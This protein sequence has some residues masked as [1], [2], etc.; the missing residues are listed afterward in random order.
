M[1]AREMLRLGLFVSSPSAAA[2][3]KPA[4]DRKPNTAAVATASNDVPLGSANRSAS[5]DSWP[6]GAAPPRKAGKERDADRGGRPPRA[7]RRPGGQRDRPRQRRLV[8]LR[9]RAADE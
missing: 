9:R 3:S 4:N 6:P 1:I 5:H 7:Q 2:P 8:P